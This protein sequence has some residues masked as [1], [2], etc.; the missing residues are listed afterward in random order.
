[1]LIG[2]TVA[3]AMPITID[4]FADPDPSTFFSLGSGISPSK[5][6][7]QLTPSALGGE[8]DSLFQVFGSANSNSIV[9]LL[10]FDT[11]YGIPAMQIGTAGLSPSV[12]TLQYS[13]IANSNTAT[14]LVNAHDLADGI[15]IDLTD[16][17]TND[18]F[19]LQFY[20]VDAHP[21]DGLDVVVTIASPGGLSSS[22]TVIVPNSQTE[23]L[24]DIPFSQ[25]VGAASI[26]DV[27][28]ITFVFNGQRKTANVD[29]EVQSIVATVPEPGGAVLAAAGA[30]ALAVY[31]KRRRTT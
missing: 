15:G 16:G 19:E 11:S 21:S 24:I 22:A 27:D 30:L 3:Q 1:M 2:I 10:G 23:S 17:G 13:G 28:G 12:A 25:L 14:A 31:V 6:F 9:G 8:R 29:F 5:A 7:S 26:T 20:T 4:S 18:R